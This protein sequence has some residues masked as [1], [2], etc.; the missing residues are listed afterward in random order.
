M[1]SFLLFCTSSYGENRRSK[2]NS[3]ISR[4]HNKTL[5]SR[6]GVWVAATRVVHHSQFISTRELLIWFWIE[7]RRENPK[8]KR[9]TAAAGLSL[10]SSPPRM[11]QQSAFLMSTCQ[12]AIHE[13]VVQL[14]SKHGNNCLYM[15][16]RIPYH[17]GPF[18][19]VSFPFKASSLSG[20]TNIVVAVSTQS[21][22]RSP[23]HTFSSIRQPL[24]GANWNGIPIAEWKCSKI[25]CEHSGTEC[26]CDLPNSH[27]CTTRGRWLLLLLQTHSNR[28]NVHKNEWTND[29]NEEKMIR[30]Y[31]I[32]DGECVR[33]QNGFY[34]GTRCRYMPPW[35]PWFS[36]IGYSEHYV[37]ACLVRILRLGIARRV[38]VPMFFWCGCC[39]LVGVL[40]LSMQFEQ[41]YSEG[42]KNI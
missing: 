25:E 5:T 35:P 39:Y 41:S 10:S 26:A 19:N 7:N 23:F 42:R 38:C 13:K 30:V 11:M 22:L 24:Y 8:L 6:L 12:A 20:T 32:Y 16:Y 28:I 14:K 21:L 36:F 17:F 33:C 3:F 29:R 37:G 34:T 1:H 27:A 18:G 15:K 2:L 40:P 4:E 31:I 9:V